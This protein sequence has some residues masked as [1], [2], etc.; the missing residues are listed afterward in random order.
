MG[1]KKFFNKSELFFE[2]FLR[3]FNLFGSHTFA[4]EDL[5]ELILQKSEIDVKE[6]DLEAV[7]R[8]FWNA[9]GQY[10]EENRTIR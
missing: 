9:F 3:I 6:N 4:R 1:S 5:D 10:E 7:V 8:D 2:G